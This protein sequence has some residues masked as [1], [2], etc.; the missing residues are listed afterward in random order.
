M[1]NDQTDIINKEL[2]TQAE[3]TVKQCIDEFTIALLVQAKIIAHQKNHDIVI[4][5]D[6]NEALKALQNVQKQPWADRLATI[7][8]SA[9]FGIS[10][11]GAIVDISSATPTT[12]VIYFAFGLIGLS[13]IFWA[14]RH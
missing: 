12:Y 3:I 13:L 5:T 7:I 10:I 11:K 14:I 2:H 8:G 1:T 9:L 4:R 6:V